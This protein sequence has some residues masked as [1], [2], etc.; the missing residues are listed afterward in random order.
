MGVLATLDASGWNYSDYPTTLAYVQNIFTNI[1]GTDIYIA[2]DSQ[3]GQLI[4]A[5]AAAMYDNN[6]TFAAVINSL[7]PTYAQGVQLSNEVLVNGISRHPATYSTA[8][9]T[10]TGTVGT[11][12]SGASAKDSNGNTWDIASGVLDSTGTVLLLATCETA[13]AV[14][15][16]A[17]TI[18]QI[19]TPIFGWLTVTNVNAATTGAD[20]ESDYLLR[21]RQA[22]STALPSVTA[23]G[24]LLGGLLSVLS[25]TR[26]AVYE[27]PTSSTDTNGIPAHS[28]AAV[29]EGGDGQTIANQIALRK[30]IGCYTY[31]TSTYTTTDSMGIAS[32]TNFSV[33]A[34]DNLKMA[35]TIHPLTGYISSTLTAIQ[36]ALSAFISGLNIGD[37]V[38]YS[39]LYTVANLNGSALGQTYN[40]TSLQ[41][42]LLSGS[43]GTADIVV[44]YNQAAA[45]AV[46]N[47]VISVS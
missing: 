2:P 45:L 26:A 28:I 23:I 32:Q 17:N 19:N 29:V 6:Q 47:V 20:T 22:L 18:N 40:I 8:T 37:D 36:T 42:G 21:Q 39:K 12:I 27:N 11:V 15:A 1:Y 3:D 7:S 24:G 34:Y 43:L 10:L 35:I 5:F 4:A 13:G 41:V 14:T 33:L 9:L 46:N 31:G 30:T 16:L 25:V 44:P 38:L